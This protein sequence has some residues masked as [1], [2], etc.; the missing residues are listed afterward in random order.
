MERQN[1]V[2]S[3]CIKLILI[4]LAV[5]F[6]LSAITVPVVVTTTRNDATATTQGT[7]DSSIGNLYNTNG[8][9]N[10]TNAVSF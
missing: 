7:T 10:I 1:T 3:K 2:K 6:V 9:L 5:V 4:I 8:T